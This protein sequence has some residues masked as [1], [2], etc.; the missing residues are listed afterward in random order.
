MKY[1]KIFM[2]ECYLIWDLLQRNTSGETGEEINEISLSM[3]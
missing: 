2:D 3:S 1:T